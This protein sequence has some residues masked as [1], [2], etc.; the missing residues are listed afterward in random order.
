[1][2]ECKTCGHRSKEI[3]KNNFVTTSGIEMEVVEYE[4]G[5]FE[6]MTLNKE[7]K[8]WEITKVKRYG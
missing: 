2:I 6:F 7:N 5:Q 4:N 1:M 3:G 8:V